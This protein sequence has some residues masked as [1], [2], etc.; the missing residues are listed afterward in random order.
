MLPRPEE[1]LPVILQPQTTR[2]LPRLLPWKRTHLWLKHSL[3]HHSRCLAPQILPHHPWSLAPRPKPLLPRSMCHRHFLR[4]RMFIVRVISMVLVLQVNYFE[5]FLNNNLCAKNYFCIL[6]PL[7]L[8][9]STWSN[10]VWRLLIYGAGFFFIV[11]GAHL[12]NGY[13]NFPWFTIL[14]YFG[15]IRKVCI[16]VQKLIFF[17]ENSG[18]FLPPMYEQSKFVAVNLLEGFVYSE[19]ALQSSLKGR[20]TGNKVWTQLKVIIIAYCWVADVLKKDLVGRDI[21]LCI[22]RVILMS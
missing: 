13:A 12:Q 18:K 14:N 16:F 15:D 22:L 4:R 8:T 2:P 11:F 20:K 1:S 7:D 19:K 5:I 21:S 10:S 3:R 9:D 17:T 6:F